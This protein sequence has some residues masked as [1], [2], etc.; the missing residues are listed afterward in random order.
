[1]K[2]GDDFGAQ[3]MCNTPIDTL[4]KCTLYAGCQ[5][6]GLHV[7]LDLCLVSIA[8][9]NSYISGMKAQQRKFAL[10]LEIRHTSWASAAGLCLYEPQRIARV[11]RK[12]TFMISRNELLIYVIDCA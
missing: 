8:D 2:K 1:M 5:Q 9:P 3:Q 12:K 4:Q 10:Q 6:F 11:E 7:R